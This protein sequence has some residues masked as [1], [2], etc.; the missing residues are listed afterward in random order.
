MRKL[1]SQ[2]IDIN[3]QY[4]PCLLADTNHCVFC[5]HLKGQ[6]VCDCNWS[7]VCILYEKHW[8]SKKRTSGNGEI[9]IRIEVETQFNIINQF[10]PD[11]YM[12]EFEV[13]SN[14]AQQLTK[15]G[16][17]VFLR[18]P[19]DPHFYHFPVGIMKVTGNSLQVVIETIGPK[20]TRIIADDN[21]QLLVRGPYYNG[22]LGQPWIDNLTNGKVV[23][24]AG[25]MGQPPALPIAAKLIKNTN[26]VIAILAP[27]AI[28]KTIIGEELCELGV[29]VHEV[30]AFRKDGIVM[31]EELCAKRP[32]L[33]VSAGPD[34]QHYAIINVLQS[35][36]VNIPMAVTNNATMCCGEG[37]CGSC[38]KETLDNKMICTCKVQT[39]FTQLVPY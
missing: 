25:G 1:L 35:I 9:P 14:L 18:R 37:I 31:L 16:S 33:L 8:Q 23:L 13:T 38:Q 19:Q 39:D 26:E 20:S 36:D 3:S 30:S 22:I 7:G 34:D 32:D 17:F 6:S 2:C 12:L 27:G 11:V 24:I 10:S 4:C 5:S 29:Q 15:T 28:G 21:R